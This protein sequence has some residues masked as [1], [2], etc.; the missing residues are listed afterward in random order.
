MKIY[1]KV[2]VLSL[3]DMIRKDFWRNSNMNE[4]LD[5]LWRNISVL[6]IGALVACSSSE[7]EETE[8]KGRSQTVGTTKP[9][10]TGI[11]Q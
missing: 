11:R 10:H 2:Q 9:F 3:F 6:A 1:I 8:N 4:N 7:W 5:T